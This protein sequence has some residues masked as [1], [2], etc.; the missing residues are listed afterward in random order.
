MLLSIIRHFST[1]YIFYGRANGRE[2]LN[3]ALSKEHMRRR[4][5]AVSVNIKITFL[6]WAMEFISGVTVIAVWLLK[7]QKSPLTYVQKLFIQCMIFLVIPATYVLN[8]E[9]TKQII[10]LENWCT[11]MKSIFMSREQVVPLINQLQN[12]N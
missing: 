1:F 9:V 6:S 5:R 4:H 11:G 7:E 2:Y 12:H 3:D 8:R 10:V